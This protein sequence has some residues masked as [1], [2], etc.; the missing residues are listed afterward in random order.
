MS[1][2]LH[3][4]LTYLVDVAKAV[5]S[6]VWGAWLLGGREAGAVA[7]LSRLP[8]RGPTCMPARADRFMPEVVAPHVLVQDRKFWRCGGGDGWWA[9]LPCVPLVLAT[10]RV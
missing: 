5:P 6:G 2:R 7:A 3:T 1:P 9:A 8:H 4:Y 10:W